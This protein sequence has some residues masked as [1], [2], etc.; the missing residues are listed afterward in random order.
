MLSLSRTIL[1]CFTSGGW[2]YHHNNNNNNNTASDLSRTFQ[3]NPI[4]LYIDVNNLIGQ[5]NLSIIILQIGEELG[6]EMGVI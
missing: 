2:F 5:I 1:N 4:A 6:D 3:D